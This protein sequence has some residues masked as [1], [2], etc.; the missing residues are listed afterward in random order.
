MNGLKGYKVLVSQKL[1]HFVTANKDTVKIQRQ[2]KRLRPQY[3]MLFVNEYTGSCPTVE[4]D[5][6]AKVT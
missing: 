1:H 3:K 4:G 2:Y 5:I 6:T